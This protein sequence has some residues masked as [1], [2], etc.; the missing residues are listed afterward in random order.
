MSR[1]GDEGSRNKEPQQV[2]AE[3]WGEG[4]QIAD[5]ELGHQT[6]YKM[7]RRSESQDTK[8][9]RGWGGRKKNAVLLGRGQRFVEVRVMNYTAHDQGDQERNIQDCFTAAR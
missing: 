1:G 9:S 6:K 3:S 8:D 5:C 4:E 2:N 7:G